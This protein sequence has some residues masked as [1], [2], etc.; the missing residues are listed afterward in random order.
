MFTI[1]GLVVY[2]SVSYVLGINTVACIL[3][4][5]QNVLAQGITFLQ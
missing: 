4:V 3:T 2:I 5:I 1:I